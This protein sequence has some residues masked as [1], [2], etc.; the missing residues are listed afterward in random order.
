LQLQSG[1]IDS[2]QYSFTGD[3]YHHHNWHGNRNWAGCFVNHA[4]RQQT[5]GFCRSHS[6]WIRGHGIWLTGQRQ[7]PY[8]S[9]NSGLMS[10]CGR[11]VF[12]RVRRRRRDFW[13]WVCANANAFTNPCSR[14]GSRH[15]SCAGPSHRYNSNGEDRCSFDSA[16]AYCSVGMS[17][18]VR[19]ALTMC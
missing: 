8:S 1:Y 11:A 9:A 5:A 19:T 3:S 13:A 2:F 7:G 16:K 14:D 12:V 17:Q 18:R 4:W 15:V 6:S 10:D